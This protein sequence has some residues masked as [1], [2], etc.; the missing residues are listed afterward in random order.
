MGAMRLMPSAGV[1]D[2]SQSVDISAL[3]NFVILVA[4]FEIL[5]LVVIGSLVD[6]RFSAQQLTLHNEHRM[7]RAL[8]DNIPDFMYVKDTQSRFVIA[9]AYTAR[10]LGASSPADLLGQTDFDFYPKELAAVFHA[11][12]PEPIRY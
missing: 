4:T 12:E 6:R 10:T 7:L 8:I 2:L 9:N 1:Q 3:A 5:G 11:D